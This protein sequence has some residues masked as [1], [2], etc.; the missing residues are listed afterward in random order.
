MQ[1]FYTK[2]IRDKFQDQKWMAKVRK[3]PFKLTFEQWVAWWESEL[4]PDWIT[5]RG[6]KS[7]QYVMARKR[8][9]GPYAIWNIECVT[10]NQ[11][12]ADM[13]KHGSYVHGENV[14]TAK[15]T[16]AQVRTIYLSNPRDEAVLAKKY[17]IRFSQIAKIK[18]GGQ[19]AAVTKD[20]GPSKV[21]GYV[22]GDMHSLATITNMQACKIFLAQGSL[23]EV[24]SKFKVHKRIVGSIK[25]GD[26]WRAITKNLGP[27]LTKRRGPYNLKKRALRP[28]VGQT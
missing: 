13:K 14:G 17:K 16:N 6:C 28:E 22:R 4:G 3:I 24:A 12:H 9:K 27:I 1:K 5:K 25:R 8:D 7:G 20:L 11:N 2:K 19:W 18:R 23:Q 10:S 26:S 15:L 21:K